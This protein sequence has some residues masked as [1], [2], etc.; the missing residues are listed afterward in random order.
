VKD[1]SMSH[2]EKSTATSVYKALVEELRFNLETGGNPLLQFADLE[3]FGLKPDNLTR[4]SGY[5]TTYN[6]KVRL[7]WE[8]PNDTDHSM[9]YRMG[10]T[11]AHVP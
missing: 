6:G 5:Y 2:D 8:F 7:I 11:R 9:L 4:L 3:P 10:S 1:L